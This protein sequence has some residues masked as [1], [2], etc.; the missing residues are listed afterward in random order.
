[1][2]RSTDYMPWLEHQRALLFKKGE[3]VE[4][5]IEISDGFE[6]GEGLKFVM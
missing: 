6:K 4:L 2:V 1:M 3:I 5:D